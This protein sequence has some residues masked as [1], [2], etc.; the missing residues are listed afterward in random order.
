MNK[1]ANSIET[2]IYSNIRRLNNLI[3]ILADI[4]YFMI[5]T[6]ISGVLC[7]LSVFV[8]NESFFQK[9]IYTVSVVFFI[10]STIKLINI[11]A[12]SYKIIN[13][14]DFEDIRIEKAKKTR[15]N[16]FQ[17]K[18]MARELL[19]IENI[20]GKKA[21]S[22]LIQEV[23]IRSGKNKKNAYFYY[24]LFFEYFDI[25]EKIKNKNDVNQKI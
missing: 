23:K 1:E 16:L 4:I 24:V 22:E 13:G 11:V 25:M 12:I 10:L 2:I 18:R 20:I 7:Y 9:T 3:S 14:N 21:Y 17:R 8:L 6:T 19:K 15:L 5:T